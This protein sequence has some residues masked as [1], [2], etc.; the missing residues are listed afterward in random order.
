MLT[1][2]KSL[3]KETLAI[4]SSRVKDMETALQSPQISLLKKHESQLLGLRVMGL[5]N[6]LRKYTICHF[7]ERTT[8]DLA[9][10]LIENFWHLKFDEFILILRNGINGRYGKIFGALQYSTIAEWF[11]AHESERQ[12][13]IEQKRIAE[14]SAL[15]ST[16]NVNASPEELY[17]NCIYTAPVKE[18]KKPVSQDEIQWATFIA[19][20]SDYTLEQLYEFRTIAKENNWTKTTSAIEGEIN[21]RTN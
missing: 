20:K 6:D 18:E 10:N 17:L 8:G 12:S 19:L 1:H 16:K 14:N 9:R 13:H 7:D 11:N 5:L 4:N 3:G 15:N 21:E 2:W